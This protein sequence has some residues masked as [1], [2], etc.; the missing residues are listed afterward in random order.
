LINRCRPLLANRLYSGLVRIATRQTDFFHI[1]SDSVI[2]LG[3][4]V[5][6]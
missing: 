4:P 2:E 5:E 6:I 1:P 3:T